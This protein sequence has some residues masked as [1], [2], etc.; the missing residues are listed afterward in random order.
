VCA[1]LPFVA[2]A[3]KQ[4]RATLFLRQTHRIQ[5]YEAMIILEVALFFSSD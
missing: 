2:R 4:R 5:M 1:S 3:C